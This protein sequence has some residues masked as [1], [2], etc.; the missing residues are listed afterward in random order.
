MK[1]RPSRRAIALVTVSTVLLAILG[2]SVRADTKDLQSLDGHRWWFDSRVV[3]YRFKHRIW[4]DFEPRLRLLRI[5]EALNFSV[6]AALCVLIGVVLLARRRPRAAA[7]YFAAVASGIIA[8][9]LLKPLFGR[10]IQDAAGGSFY[11]FPS[12]H[13]A[14]LS[15]TVVAWV[16]HSRT[17]KIAL[18]KSGVGAIVVALYAT[19]LSLTGSHFVTDCIGGALTS[20]AVVVGVHVA[21][22]VAFRPA[23][24]PESPSN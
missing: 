4:F 21:S 9:L 11:T 19:L 5:E 16:L 8:S 22:S 24:E 6:L 10:S 15:G 2:W 7:L 17:T 13:T 23:P 18:A 20:I 14:L 3:Q 12:G 1:A